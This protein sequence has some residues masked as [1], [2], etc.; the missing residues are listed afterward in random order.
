MKSEVDP[1][2]ELGVAE[3]QDADGFTAWL[4][5]R[6]EQGDVTDAPPAGDLDDVTKL[7]R[8]MK[9]CVSRGCLGVTASPTVFDLVAH[10]G[11]H[12]GDAG[13]KDW[14]RRAFRLAV[15]E[16]ETSRGGGVEEPTETNA[17]ELTKRPE[18]QARAEA[19]GCGREWPYGPNVRH[20]SRLDL[21]DWAEPLR[22]RWAPKGRCLHWLTKGR[23]GVAVCTHHQGVWFDHPSGWTRD[24][25]PDRL[26]IQ[27]YQLAGDDLSR[28]AALAELYHVELSVRG[29]GWYGS[30]TVWIAFRRQQT[31]APLKP[32]V[33]LVCPR[34]S[35][36]VEPAGHPDF[37][38]HDGRP[39]FACN[40]CREYVE[41]N[42]L[43]EERK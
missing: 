37:P 25:K 35:G 12:A 5:A 17:L 21:V 28:M 39:V 13:L 19:V 22:L 9:Q 10:A 14:T 7:A 16:H 15:L 36:P 2:P 29:A 27:P 20:Q 43:T 11:R 8:A 32:K 33:P 23:C 40:H 18:F 3:D 38:T 41:P 24:S 30:P 26:I 6:A 4:L 42:E 31:V 1:G 34:C